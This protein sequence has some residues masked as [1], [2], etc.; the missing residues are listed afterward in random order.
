MRPSGRPQSSTDE[1]QATFTQWPPEE[2]IT[3]VEV[4]VDQSEPSKDDDDSAAIPCTLW[5]FSL[6]KPVLSSSVGPDHVPTFPPGPKPTECETRTASICSTTTSFVES[7]VNG[8]PTTVSSRVLPP[9]CAG[10]RGCLVADYTHEASVTRT[11][12]ATKTVTNVVVTCSGTGTAACSTRNG[13][14]ETECDVTATTTTVSCTPAPTGNNK[15]QEGDGRSPA[16]PIRRTYVIWPR[17]GTKT[18]ETGA[19]YSEVKTIVEDDHGIRV[20]E[21]NGLGV[22]FW[23]VSMNAGQ[24]KR[25]KAIRSVASVHVE[26][27]SGCV[28]PT[29]ADTNW[30]YQDWFLEDVEVS[31]HQRQI[32]FLSNNEAELRDEFNSHYFFDEF[33]EGDN[34]AA[35]TEFLF[36]GNDYDGKQHRDD[37]GAKLGGACDPEKCNP[38]G[39]SILSVLAGANLGIV[40]KVK[41]MV[42][43]APRRQ[44]DGSGSTDQEVDESFE[45][46]KT[47][48]R[49]ILRNLIRKGLF[50]VT[51]SGNTGVMESYPALFADENAPAE[52]RI[53]ELLVVGATEMYDGKIW[54]KS[55]RKVEAKLP[56]ISWR[57]GCEMTVDSVLPGYPLGQGKVDC[58]D[59]FYDNWRKCTGNWGRGGYIDAGCLR[60]EFTPKE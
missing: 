20:S 45:L 52:L 36:V 14:R 60:Y 19:I 10:L 8:S 1:S 56:H 49:A 46:F 39:T 24:A 31:Q 9:T 50:V 21:A 17:D 6:A 33:T 40:K 47:R 22:N 41:P 32:S 25:V 5:F 7:T 51:G 34:I 26:C 42:V 59:L 28:D 15:L 13:L 38:H 43:R 27:T 35:K 29:T 58:G 54:G 57:D 37:S 4:E 12:C 44:A 2:G 3:P 16:C 48:L 55:G 53:P 30:R 18:D 11:Q 23:R